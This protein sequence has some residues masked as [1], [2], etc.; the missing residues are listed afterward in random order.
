M[1]SLEKIDVQVQSNGTYVMITER[2]F[3]HLPLTHKP[4]W[5]VIILDKVQLNEAAQDYVEKK[6]W[7]FM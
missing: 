6:G 2:L 7:G 5:R 1:S 4:N 3:E